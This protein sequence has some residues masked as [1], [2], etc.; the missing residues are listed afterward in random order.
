MWNKIAM[1]H[2][3]GI[4]ALN[5]SLKNIR[6]NKRLMGGVTVL[7]AKNFRQTLPIVLKKTK[8]DEVK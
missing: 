7:W 6:G 5:R 8:T 2:K 1:A 3:A 4:E